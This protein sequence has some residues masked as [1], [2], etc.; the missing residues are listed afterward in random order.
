V[1][2][3]YEFVRVTNNGPTTGECIYL[4]TNY[5]KFSKTDYQAGI[6]FP[7]ISNIP[8]TTS[9]LTLSFDWC[10]MR[11]KST[12]DEVSL[13]VN[14]INGSDTTT[15]ATL[16]H[17][18]TELKLQWVHATVDLSNV[19]FDSTSRIFLR[20]QQW[21]TTGVHRWFLDNIKVYG[22]DASG[23]ETTIADENAPAEYYNLQ[24]VRVANPAKGFYVKRQGNKATKVFLQ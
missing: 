1:N 24:G 5:L 11:N 2:R 12:F 4:Q 14:V 3:G 7:A 23:I 13:L 15:V 19:K 18:L 10:P 8:A 22:S 6:I 20:S 16:E 9:G 21:I 17:G